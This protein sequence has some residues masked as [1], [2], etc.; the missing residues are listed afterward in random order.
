MLAGT[1]RKR[2]PARYAAWLELVTML[3]L[4]AIMFS[5]CGKPSVSDSHPQLLGTGLAYASPTVS[6]TGQGAQGISIKVIPARTNL[7]AYPGGFM[8]LAITTAPGALC[9]FVVAYG[10]GAASKDVGIVPV[11]ADASGL[12][13]WRWQVEHLAHTG[14]WPLMITATLPNGARTTSQVQVTVTPAPIN[15]VASQSLLA[16]SPRQTMVLTVSTAPSIYCSLLLNYGPGRPSK[17]LNALANGQG[18]ATWTWRVDSSAVS[19]NWPLTIIAV[20][21]SGD[22]SYGQ[23]DM[24]I[25]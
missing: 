13:R 21:G 19:G 3:A 20:L 24:T 14:T 5:G 8:T 4:C 2:S 10:P 16:A 23:V 15:V 6:A 11:A 22:R 9:S 18:I 12:A 17:T 7:S 25:L 1:T